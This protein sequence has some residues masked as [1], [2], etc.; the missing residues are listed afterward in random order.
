[1]QDAQ[2]AEYQTEI[3]EL[4][5]KLVELQENE[6]ALALIE[7]YSAEVR[8]LVA[9]LGAAVRLSEELQHDPELGSQLA[10]RGFQPT[11]FREI[12]AFVYESSLEIDRAGTEFAREVDRT[13]FSQLLRE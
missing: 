7:E 9:L 1:M 8:I 2:L 6:A 4:Q 12:Y 3:A 11:H 10:M 5:R 13:D